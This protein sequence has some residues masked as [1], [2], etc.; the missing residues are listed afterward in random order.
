MN[1]HMQIIFETGSWR[2]QIHKN[3]HVLQHILREQSE[4]VGLTKGDIRDRS[5]T[6]LIFITL[7]NI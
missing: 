2:K 5:S 6:G 4:F 7:F 1:G 3:T